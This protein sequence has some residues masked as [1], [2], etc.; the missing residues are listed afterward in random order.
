MFPQHA[1][2]PHQP[3]RCSQLKDA[4]STLMKSNRKNPEKEAN[5]GS[6]DSAGERATD[7]NQAQLTIERKRPETIINCFLEATHNLVGGVKPGNLG[8]RFTVC[9]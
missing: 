6:N 4:E 5:E 9:A 1:E 2:V 7:L 3:N 8:A